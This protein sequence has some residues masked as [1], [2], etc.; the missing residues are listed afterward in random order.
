[1]VGILGESAAVFSAAYEPTVATRTSVTRR[2]FAF[3]AFDLASGAPTRWGSVFTSDQLVHQHWAKRYAIARDGSVALG[4]FGWEDHVVSA[5]LTKQGSVSF[6]YTHS[7]VREPSRAA[8]SLDGQ[9][10]AVGLTLKGG[11]RSYVDIVDMASGQLKARW[12][13]QPLK[14]RVSFLQF[15]KDRTLIVAS[16]G[17]EAARISPEGK[18]VW[19]SSG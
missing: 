3:Y 4:V 2:P 11:N 18:L 8:V 9:L 5:G 19:K 17:H 12:P 6:R 7:G 1:M 10:S 15:L 13:A 16:S 14:G